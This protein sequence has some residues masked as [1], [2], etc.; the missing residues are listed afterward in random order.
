MQS[1]PTAGQRRAVAPPPLQ[2]APA[3]TYRVVLT[4]DGQEFVQ[5]LRLELDPVL[6]ARALCRGGG[7]CCGN[8]REEEEDSTHG[9][10]R[11]C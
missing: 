9:W 5:S 3:G 10:S 8:G 11:E 1:V 4:K 2:P 7:G 6:V